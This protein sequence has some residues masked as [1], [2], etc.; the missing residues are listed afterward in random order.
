MKLAEKSNIE[1]TKNCVFICHKESGTYAT[2]LSHIQIGEIIIS[3]NNK[4]VETICDII[5]ILGDESNS[6]NIYSFETSNYH[7]IYLKNTEILYG[8]KIE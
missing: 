2:K 3:V 8:V 5:N 6:K 1:N 7:K 4:L